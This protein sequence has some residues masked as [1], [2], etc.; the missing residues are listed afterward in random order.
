[1][2]K[3]KISWSMFSFVLVFFLM[4][5]DTP[6]QGSLETNGNPD[7]T[8]DQS[9][10]Q[11][12]FI[13]NRA[14]QVGEEITYKLYYNWNFVWLAAGEVVFN[15]SELDGKYHI[16]AKGRTY[17]TYEW[18]FKVRDH[19]ESYLDKETLL[20]QTSIRDVH[21]GGYKLYDKVDFDQEKN[22]A[23]SERGKTKHETETKEY[24][25]DGCMHDVLSVVYYTRNLDFERY[26]EG[27]EF[28][29]K[30]FMDKEVW[31]LNVK[32][33]G[34]EESKKIKGQGKFKTIKFSPEVIEG[35]VFKTNTE[36]NIWVSDDGNRIPLLIESPVSVG[37]VKAVL[38]NYKGLKYEMTS[39]IN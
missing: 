6:F 30:I 20:P 16:S 29:V 1:M 2:T 7:A 37:S 9:Q 32:Y 10:S 12:C 13:E 24:S 35:E 39:K 17:K 31:P 34:K 22:L 26:G 28:P 23:V 4:A 21:E 8:F 38:K 25:L 36:M 33:K 3:R 27:Q 19:Y 14:F 15:V 18:F 5:F 11:Q